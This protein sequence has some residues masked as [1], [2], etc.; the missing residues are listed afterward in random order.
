LTIFNNNV[1]IMKMETDNIICYLSEIGH[2]NF[3]YPTLKRAIITKNCLLEK[4]HWISGGPA[5]LEAYKAPRSC[6]IPVE[7]DEDSIKHTNPPQTEGYTVI[8]IEK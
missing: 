2:K 3:W 8:W 6:L 4:L 1:I 7:F 5:K